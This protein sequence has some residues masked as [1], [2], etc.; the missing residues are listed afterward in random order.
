MAIEIKNINKSFKHD[1]LSVLEDINLNID[2]GKFVCLLG[3]SG[4]GKTTLLRLISGLDKPSSGEI[5]ADG[6]VVKGPSGDRAVIFQQYSLFPW[7]TVLDNVMFGLNI[8]GKASKEENLKTAERYLERVG[9]I[10]FKDNS[11][12]GRIIHQTPANYRQEDTITDAEYRSLRKMM[13]DMEK[14]IEIYNNNAIKYYDNSDGKYFNIDDLNEN[15]IDKLIQ[16][17][18]FLVKNTCDNESINFIKQI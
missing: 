11:Y 7:L 6:E 2:D 5:I 3:P 9:L 12:T 14:I 17:K 18:E 10:E 16:E 1:E 8:S 15:D 4:C 13:F